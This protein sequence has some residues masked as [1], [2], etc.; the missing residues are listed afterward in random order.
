MNTTAIAVRVYLCLVPVSLEN[1]P[2]SAQGGKGLVNEYTTSV[3]PHWIVRPN[4]RTVFNHVIYVASPQ[5][6]FED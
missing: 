4:Q 6:P 3:L 1:Q 2:T 5:H